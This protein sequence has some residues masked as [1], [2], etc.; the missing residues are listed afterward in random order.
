MLL[1][2]GRTGSSW[3][4]GILNANPRVL[5]AGEVL[6]TMI[7]NG[8]SDDHQRDWLRVAM[9]PP[10]EYDQFAVG[11]KTKLS[12]PDPAG[13]DP[14]A[15]RE[16]LGGGGGLDAFAAVLRETN[17]RVIHMTRRNVVKLAVSR[18]NRRRL[19]ETTGHA[20]IRPDQGRLGKFRVPTTFTETEIAQLELRLRAVEEFNEQLG[21]ASMEI[22]YEDLLVD[23]DAIASQVAAFLG[24]PHVPAPGYL[25]KNTPD[26]LR[27][28]LENY[29]EIAEHL[30]G[31]RYASML[32]EVLIRQDKRRSSP[33]S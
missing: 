31:T 28:A 9:A 1:F 5:F 11:F 26:D 8:R 21:L 14:T 25:Q 24:V 10:P 15:T 17:A 3:L 13:Q 32:S 12:I 18:F 20:N 30:A 27:L 7:K 6:T 19:E 23:P 16:I 2:N 33:T 22:V 29:D 4:R